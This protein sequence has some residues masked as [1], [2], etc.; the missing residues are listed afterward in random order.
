[1]QIKI[2]LRYYYIPIE[3]FDNVGYWQGTK[4]AR[5]LTYHFWKWKIEH[6]L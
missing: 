6:S 5:A 1:M 3:Y 2:T 4:E